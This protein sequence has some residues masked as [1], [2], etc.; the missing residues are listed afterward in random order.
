MTTISSSTAITSQAS[1]LVNQGF[2]EK[3]RSDFLIG[4]IATVVCT[5]LN[6]ITGAAV[7]TYMIARLGT[8]ALADMIGCDSAGVAGKVATVV[9]SVLAA[10]IATF[11]VL[12]ALGV[13]IIFTPTSVG[14]VIGTIAFNV[15][16]A[17]IPNCS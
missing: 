15:L 7:G 1:S 11:G 17:L 9:A 5:F 6:P 10:N 16:F 2:L 14:L 3:H 8:E 13:T 12:T 4:G